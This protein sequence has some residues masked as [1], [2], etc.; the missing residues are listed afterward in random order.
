[1]AF[2][3]VLED[4]LGV[5]LGKWKDEEERVIKIKRKGL[6]FDSSLPEQ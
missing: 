1:M 5:G 2:L 6:L 3:M 4:D